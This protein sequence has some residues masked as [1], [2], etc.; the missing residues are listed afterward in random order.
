MIL[1]LDFSSEVPIYM[2]IR[3]QIVVAISG[4]ELKA[5]EKLPTIRALAQEAGINTMTVNKAYGLLK[6]EGFICADRRSGAVVN[7]LGTEKGSMD[8]KLTKQL[9]LL[10]SEARLAR[11]EKEEFLKICTEIY[12]RGEDG[13]L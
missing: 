9:E 13:C 1:Q 5:G 3:N 2:Q 8:T 10:I 4:G 6:Q 11:V 7:S 12:E